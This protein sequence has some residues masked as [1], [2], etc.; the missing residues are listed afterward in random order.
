[1]KQAITEGVDPAG[2]ELNQFMPRWQISAGDL[3]DLVNYI[4]TLK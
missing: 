3:N 2:D 4:M 1:L